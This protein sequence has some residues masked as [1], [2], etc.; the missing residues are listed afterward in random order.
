[1][2]SPTTFPAWK[3][4]RAG[5]GAARAT[6]RLNRTPA[7]I[8]GGGLA[9]A[10][11]ALDPKLLWKTLQ[12]GHFYS[13]VYKIEIEDG[14]LEQALVR[15]VQF[16]PVTDQPLHVD[17]LRISATSTIHVQVPVHFI[18]HDKCTG[19]RRGGVLNI[20]RHEVEMVCN[21]NAIPEHLTV[22]LAGRDIG[23]SIH[24]SMIAIPEGSHPAITDRD[25]TVATLAPPTVE[26]K[27]TDAAEGAEP[28]A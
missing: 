3:R 14:A 5:K 19:L 21:A 8:Y 18:N 28:A 26:T 7:V 22:D 25:F 4:D 27:T 13:T 2:S 17:F 9:P 1:M 20:V 12:E 23:D 6:R 11:I 10:L 16:H 24:I 15:D